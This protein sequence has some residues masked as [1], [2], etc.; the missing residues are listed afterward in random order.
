MSHWMTIG[1]HNIDTTDNEAPERRS[2]MTHMFTIHPIVFL[3][4]SNVSTL[5][6]VMLTTWFFDLS[7]W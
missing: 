6:N 5:N 7:P 3:R 4:V 1:G 2:I